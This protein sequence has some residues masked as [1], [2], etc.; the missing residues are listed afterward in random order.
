LGL[1]NKH[2]PIAKPGIGSGLDKQYSAL[3]LTSTKYFQSVAVRADGILIPNLHKALFVGSHF[4]TPLNSTHTLRHLQKIF[5]ILIFTLLGQNL[6]AQT[7]NCDKSKLTVADKKLLTQFWTD[8]KSA[9]NSEN[10]IKLA[11][12]V[13]FPFKCDYCILDTTKEK[14]YDYL[15]VTKKLFDKGQYKIFFDQKLKKTV[16]KNVNLLDILFVVFENKKCF[17][18]FSYTSVEPSKEWEGQQHFFSLNKINGKYFI[19]SAWTVP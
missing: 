13:K 12:L 8:F 6:F 3:V 10:K 18:N 1:T 4:R 17:Y 2:Q 14:D 15:K 7:R 16:N 11:S 9:I 5:A 19:T